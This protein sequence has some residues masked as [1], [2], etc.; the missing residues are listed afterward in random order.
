[1]VYIT[2]ILRGIKIALHQPEVNVSE[3][4]SEFDMLKGLLL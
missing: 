1:M 3:M 2:R 4:V